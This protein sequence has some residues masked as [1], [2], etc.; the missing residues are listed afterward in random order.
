MN[1]IFNLFL[2]I[3]PPYLLFLVGPP[4]SGKSTFIKELKRFHIVNDLDFFNIISR[5][6]LVLSI[7]G[8]T[9]YDLAWNSVDQK[10]VDRSLKALVEDLSVRLENVV[11]DMT[12]MTDKRKNYIDKFPSHYKIAIVFETDRETLTK[13][14]LERKKKTNKYIPESVIDSMIESY[15][16]PGLTEGFDL[17]IKF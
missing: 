16:P 8:K 6:D 7:S 1:D 11:I 10:E 9:D 14:N 15:K 5:D 3:K 4:L 12:N 17:I 2:D 13:R